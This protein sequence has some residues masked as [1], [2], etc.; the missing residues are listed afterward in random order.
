[1]SS[2]TPFQKACIERL[3]MHKADCESCIYIEHE[4]G[5]YGQFP[6]SYCK[7]P[8]SNLKSFPFKKTMPC[9][10][11]SVMWSGFLSDDF[12][13]DEPDEYTAACEKF[14]E[15]LNEIEAE[16]GQEVEDGESFTETLQKTDGAKE[17]FDHS[18]N[19]PFSECKE[20]K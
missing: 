5:E 18:R 7:E 8:C 11:P 3:K 2:P 1:M 20:L 19:I 6:Q 12:D 14:A 13:G 16:Y 4:C 10:F 15:E 17:F 9:W